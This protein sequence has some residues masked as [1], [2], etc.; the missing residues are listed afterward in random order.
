MK[1]PGPWYASL[2]QKLNT[3]ETITAWLGGEFIEKPKSVRTGL[4]ALT[5][6]RLIFYRRKAFGEEFLPLGPPT[7]VTDAEV[8]AYAGIY[9]NG[10]SSPELRIKLRNGQQIRMS[11]FQQGAPDA[12]VAALLAAKAGG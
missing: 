10:R 9:V 6:E 8:G 12:F 2:E 5:T 4:L 3:G 7:D 11:L 1:N